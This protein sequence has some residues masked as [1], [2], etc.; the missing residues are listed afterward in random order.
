MVGGKV[1]HKH[2]FQLFLK[3]FKDFEISASVKLEVMII[4]LSLVSIFVSS[5]SLDNRKI[6]HNSKIE[7]SLG[8]T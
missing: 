2:N 6:R 7:S 3:I 4:S 8:Y 1:F 5:G